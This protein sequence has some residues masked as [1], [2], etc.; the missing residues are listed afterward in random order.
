MKLFNLASE[1]NPPPNQVFFLLTL[2]TSIVSHAADLKHQFS[3]FNSQGSILTL[4]AHHPLDA[5]Y[6]SVV[7]GSQL[8]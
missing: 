2:K 4:Q 5:H 6:Y 8:S 3:S 1:I 7:D